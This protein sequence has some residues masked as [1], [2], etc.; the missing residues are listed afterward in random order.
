MNTTLFFRYNPRRRL[1]EIVWRSVK[2]TISVAQVLSVFRNRNIPC[3]KNVAIHEQITDLGTETK[4][5]AAT[6]YP[7]IVF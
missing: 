4:L 1:K 2:N 3:K 6:I 5:L 7:S